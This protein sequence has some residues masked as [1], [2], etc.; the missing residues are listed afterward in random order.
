MSVLTGR[1]FKVQDQLA[2]LPIL[3]GDI[4][5]L[6][7]FAPWGGITVTTTYLVDLLFGRVP[8]FTGSAT[9]AGDGRF[10][11]SS[12]ISDPWQGLDVWVALTVSSGVPLYRS[13]FVRLQDVSTG[14]LNFWLFPD[15]LPSSDG[16]TAGSI[17]QQLGS[18]LPAGTI[19]TTGP[20]GLDLAGINESGPSPLPSDQIHVDLGVAITSDST[21]NLQTFVD[22]SIRYA[23]INIDFPTSLFVSNDQVLQALQS[24]INGAAGGLNSTVLTKMEGILESQDNVSPAMAQKF[25][26][27]EVSVTF[28]NVSFSSHQWGIGN[29]SDQT[30]V[31]TADPCI[32]FPRT[33]TP[34]ELVL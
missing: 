33:A 21:P 4:P 2:L 19:L 30:I 1:V 12:D 26:T 13:G 27:E 34:G 14:Q 6:F 11:V 20:A 28:T 5:P 22:V 25:F 9:T 31:I 32:G 18:S 15:T 10:S 23:D 24:A 3:F 16:I 17:S 29:T 7:G 8:I